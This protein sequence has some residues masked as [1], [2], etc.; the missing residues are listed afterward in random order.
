[1]V[2][3]ASRKSLVVLCFFSSLLVLSVATETSGADAAAARKMTPGGAA[4]AADDTPRGYRSSY[5]VPGYGAGNKI[6]A[7]GALVTFC[8]FF[9]LLF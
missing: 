8:C 1:M 9:P 7:S 4:G 5:P 6:M 3:S 2:L